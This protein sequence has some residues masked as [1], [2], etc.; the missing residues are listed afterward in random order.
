[1]ILVGFVLVLRITCIGLFSNTVYEYK[2]DCRGK[3]LL[4]DDFYLVEQNTANELVNLEILELLACL[5]FER[6]IVF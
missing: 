1:M 4:S 5:G 6:E 3:L 2:H